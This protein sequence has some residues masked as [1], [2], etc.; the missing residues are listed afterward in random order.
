MSSI[1]LT[2][3]WLCLGRKRLF[4]R[5][6]PI[7]LVFGLSVGL[8]V[9]WIEEPKMQS[10]L[11]PGGTFLTLG[12]M[13]PLVLMRWAGVR[14]QN[15]KLDSLAKI[16][17]SNE[18]ETYVNLRDIFLFTT[19]SAIVTSI[20]REIPLS[21]WYAF[22]FDRS[23]L[24]VVGIHSACLAIISVLAIWTSF[25]SRGFVSRW[26]PW[27]VVAAGWISIS[28]TH[29]LGPFF[30]FLGPFAIA[31]SATLFIGCHSYRM[32]GWRFAGT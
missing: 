6:A 10:V 5:T 26:G 32:R 18:R 25:S 30:Y 22:W 23:F 12:M 31:S 15:T 13:L 27:L 3:I 17:Q 20:F 7:V 8:I 14:F 16:R 28:A 24:F 11:I 1:V 2:N 4:R 19:V 21:H 29:P 9:C